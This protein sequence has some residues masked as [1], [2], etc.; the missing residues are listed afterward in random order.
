VGR[1]RDVQFELG[2]QSPETLSKEEL[3]A[4]L[5]NIQAKLGRFWGKLTDDTLLTPIVLQRDSAF[6]YAD[7]I[8]GQIRHVQ[9]H[10][11]HCNGILRQYGCKT[12]GWLGYHEE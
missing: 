7:A 12:V 6:T 5:Q 10:V 3:S 9:H 11:G 8:L 4:Y 2:V 1:K